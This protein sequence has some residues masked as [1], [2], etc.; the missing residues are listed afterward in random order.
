MLNREASA[1]P[2]SIS[3]K[4]I[5]IL[6]ADADESLQAVYRE[7]LSHEGFA[8]TAAYSGLECVARLREYVPDVLVLEPCLPWG[9]GDGVLSV[10]GEVPALANIP[11][12]VLTSCRDSRILSRLTRFPVSEYQIKPLSPLR[13]AEKLRILVRHPRLHFSLS[14]QPDRLECMIA[15]RTGGRVRNL[16]VE[17]VDGRVIAHGCCDSFHVRQLAKAAVL[18]AFEA[19]ESQSDRIELDISVG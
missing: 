2:R 7:T 3:S 9:G 12:I 13:L 8:V 17:T 19:S 15:K 14:E 10:I 6:I 16:H 11:V 1:Q 18:E 5:R 4:C